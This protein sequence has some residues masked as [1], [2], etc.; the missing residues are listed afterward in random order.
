MTLYICYL[1]I[2]ISE[3]FISFYYFGS[4]YKSKVNNR[5]L[6]FIYALIGLISFI[7]SRIDN[8]PLLNAIMFIASNF[9]LLTFCYS[10]N[11]KSRIY[12]TIILTATMIASETIVMNIMTILFDANLYDV[13]HNTFYLIMLSALSKLLYFFAIYL[14][15]KFTTREKEQE[16]HILP[17]FLSI[18]PISS[19][20]W[21]I[22]TYYLTLVYNLSEFLKNTLS[23]CN[24]LI[25]LSN[26]VV[27]FVYEQTLKTNRLYTELL[28]TKQ[29]EQNISDYYKLLKEQ[30]DNSKILIH[31]ITKHLNS[32]K[33]LSN[34]SSVDIKEYISHIV[35]DFNI[36]NPIDYC[37]NSLLNLITNRYSIICKSENINF[38]INIQNA[39]IDFMSEP[40]ITALFDNILENAV[41]SARQTLEKFINFSIDIRNTNFVVITLSNSSNKKPL[42]KNGKIISSKNDSTMHGIGTKSIKRVIKKYDGIINMNYLE[43][44]KTFKTTITFQL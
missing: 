27:F 30:N 42:M 18:L 17:I 14:F 35:E 12:N 32:I 15:A 20:I 26:I 19:V 25:L 2:Y 34:D 23:F 21:M 1:F 11:I 8:I 28:L 31:D 7:V 44:E 43:K 38:D 5:T 40:D 33:M 29:K 24:I 10:T 22:S 39:K 4:K 16:S 13:S 37:N 6:F 3:A 36:M 41:E 9:L